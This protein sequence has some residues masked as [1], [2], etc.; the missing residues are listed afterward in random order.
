MWVNVMI[1]AVSRREFKIGLL[2]VAIVC[3]VVLLWAWY[4]IARHNWYI[5]NCGHIISGEYKKKTDLGPG[6]GVILLQ[7]TERCIDILTGKA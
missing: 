2:C 1:E 5:E 4:R 6:D 7:K 3:A